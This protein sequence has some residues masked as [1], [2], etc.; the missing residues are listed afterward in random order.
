MKTTVLFFL[1]ISLA[2]LQGKAQFLGGF[3]SQQATKKKLML[4]QIAGLEIYLQGI[5]GGYMITENG[6]NVAHELKNGTFGF[7]AAY[8]N[9]LEQVNPLVH[10]DPKG[11]A[12]YDMH[13]QLVRVFDT[14]VAW[15][16]KKRLLNGKELAYLQAV[17][18]NLL[19]ESRKDIDE[20]DAVLTPAKLRLTDQQRLERLDRIYGKMKDKYAFA[21]YFTAKCRKLATAR[22][23]AKQ[24]N[25]QLRKLYGID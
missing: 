18:V 23:K 1:F 2:V 14:E 3:F 10:S 25:K 21:H 15:Q 7:H 12:V 22:L 4:E 16:Q 19:K 9:S 11:K 8:I 17:Y 24:E 6:L 20:L 5:K 13:Q